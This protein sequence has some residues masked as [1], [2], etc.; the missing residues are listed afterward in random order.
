MD[1]SGNTLGPVVAQPAPHM[2]YF[3]NDGE[4]LIYI[5]E[6]SIESPI[7]SER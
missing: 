1:T 2:I 4:W 6:V 5:G 7:E 3:G